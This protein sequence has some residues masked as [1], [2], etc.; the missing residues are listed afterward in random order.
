MNINTM[1]AMSKKAQLAVLGALGNGAAGSP[2]NNHQAIL[3]AAPIGPAISPSFTSAPFVSRTGSVE[4][5]VTATLSKNGGTLAAGD[6]VTFTLV[7]DTGPGTLIGGEARV[8]ATT[9]GSDV[10]ATASLAWI[11]GVTPGVSHVY[12]VVATIAGASH[13]GGFLIGEAVVVLK[14]V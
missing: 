14:D 11:T 8:T 12:S 5:I 10:V 3:N 13:T 9:S 4:I 6:T 1:R 7:E 2:S